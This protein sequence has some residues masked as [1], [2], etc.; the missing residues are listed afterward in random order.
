MGYPWPSETGD[1]F[2]SF[3]NS[4]RWGWIRDDVC[5]LEYSKD[6]VMVLMVANGGICFDL[7]VSRF[8]TLNRNNL[9]VLMEIHHYVTIT[10]FTLAVFT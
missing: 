4:K 1:T 2:T 9:N 10:G 7:I 6:A 3:K 8:M 5:M